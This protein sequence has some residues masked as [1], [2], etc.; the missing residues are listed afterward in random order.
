MAVT[1]SEALA[2]FFIPQSSKNTSR[3]SQLCTAWPRKRRDLAWVASTSVAS[4]SKPYTLSFVYPGWKSVYVNPGVT[5]RML[6]V[7]KRESDTIP[8][9][10]FHQVA[11]NVDFQVRFHWEP[12][13]IAFWDNRIVTHTAT[14]DFWPQTRHALRATSHG[15]KPESVEEYERRTGKVESQMNRNS[16]IE[17]GSVS[18]TWIQ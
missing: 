14:L 3:V 17:E 5:R 4:P 6:G 18:G 9:V 16:S 1:R 2:I 8:N 10:L 7:P 13:S 12:N 15:E 11:K